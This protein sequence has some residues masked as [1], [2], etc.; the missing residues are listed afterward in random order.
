VYLLSRPDR[1]NSLAGIFERA[2]VPLRS[3]IH[4]SHNIGVFQVCGL[5]E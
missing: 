3:A 2:L 5:E 1:E 4:A